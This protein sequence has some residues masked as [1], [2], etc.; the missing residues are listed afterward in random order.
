MNEVRIELI[1]T[2]L[3]RYSPTHMR[4]KSTHPDGTITYGESLDYHCCV[5]CDFC[6]K[7]GEKMT[8]RETKES[9]E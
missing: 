3:E 9:E 7:C 2:E 8:E 4:V 1:E 5:G 6:I